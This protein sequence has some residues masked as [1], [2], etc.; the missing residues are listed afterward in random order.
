M[1]QKR[2]SLTLLRE[3]SLVEHLAQKTEEPL[4]LRV[5]EPLLLHSGTFEADFFQMNTFICCS[6]LQFLQ[7]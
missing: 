7:F 3:A 1:M 5:V 4:R 2:R 6:A